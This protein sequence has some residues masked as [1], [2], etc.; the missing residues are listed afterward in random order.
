MALN[1]ATIDNFLPA[2]EKIPNN[3]PY[4]K[5]Q[6][7]ANK[8]RVLSSAI[9][10]YE[11]WTND[12]KPVR[13]KTPFR[14]HEN[15]KL[16]PKTGQVDMKYFWAFSV[17]DYADKK[18]KI[19]EITQKGIQQKIMNLTKNEDWG[20][21]KGYDLTVT[22]SGTG[23]DTEYDVMPSPAKDLPTEAAEQ[24]ASMNINL[25]ALYSGENPF[26]ESVDVDEVA[27]ELG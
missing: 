19:L 5:F 2:D 13:S 1:Q 27:K 15:G 26:G 6:E 8:F 24:F 21:P 12:N 3:S 22:R 14:H 20:N 4:L 23:M 25:E 7:G 9:T 16:N 17:F 18:V 11:Y 10:G